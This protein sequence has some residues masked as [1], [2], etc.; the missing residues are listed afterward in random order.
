M[1]LLENASSI[2]A[3]LI[4]VATIITLIYAATKFA[5]KSNV[6][7][8]DRLDDLEEWRKGV[9]DRLA[10]GDDRFESIDEGNRIM[11]ESMLA[12]MSHLIDGK[13]DDKLT[14]ARDN[15]QKYLIRRK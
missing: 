14:T 7:Q 10:Q 12:L 2:L 6:S 11:Q 4:Q 1:E 5:G 15:L 3:L 9:D 13:D 8:N